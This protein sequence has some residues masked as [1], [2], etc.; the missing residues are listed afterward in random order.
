LYAIVPFMTVVPVVPTDPEARIALLS[1]PYNLPD[2]SVPYVDGVPRWPWDGAVA[3]QRL[4][5]VARRMGLTLSGDEVLLESASNDVWLIGGD[6]LR[7]CW[8][9]DIDRL[10]REAAVITALPDA[11]PCP[12]PLECGRDD[13]LGWTLAPRVRGSSLADGWRDTPG[14]QL[15]EYVL[16]LAEMLS[17]LHA[18]TPPERVLHVLRSAEAADGDDAVTLTGKTTIPL[19]PEQ[20]DRLIGHLRTM[21]YVDHALLDTLA[22]RLALVHGRLAVHTLPRAVLH[23]DVAPTNVLVGGGRVTA[24]IDYEW[25]RLGPRDAE[26]NMPA[27]WADWQPSEARADRLIA[28]L[29]DGYPDLFAASDL[30]ERLWLYRAGFALRCTVHWP[31]DQPE[32]GLSA[33]HPVRILRE[34]AGGHSG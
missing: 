22:E 13:H 26:L 24:L 29:R 17:T 28:W 6:V 16:Q 21:P 30:D 25:T 4:R 11:V 23:G 10:L 3:H 32:Q 1:G 19:S 20:H 2:G 7:V 9:G 31:P 33:T 8:R 5:R 34:L 12:R 15:R 27:V 14:P 18:W